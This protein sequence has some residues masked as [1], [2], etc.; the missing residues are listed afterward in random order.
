MSRAVVK[1][2][3]ASHSRELTKAYIEHCAVQT[4]FGWFDG[5]W[6]V[7]NYDRRP[8]GRLRVVAGS[9]YPEWP[10][11]LSHSGRSSA[12]RP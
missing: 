12:N 6:P 7:V 9:L 10:V 4:I 3:F 1:K 2:T 11:L 8:R 5:A